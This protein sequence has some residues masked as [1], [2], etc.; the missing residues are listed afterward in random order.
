ML[1]E[2]I[3]ATLTWNYI[4][5][6]VWQNDCT[7]SNTSIYYILK[8][9]VTKGSANPETNTLVQQIKIYSVY[10]II[11]ASQINI[12]ESPFPQG[13]IDLKTGL[14]LGHNIKYKKKI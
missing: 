3:G 2:F 11:L 9:Y 5:K 10:F 14:L 12:H 7:E 6:R 13:H 1:K 8:F 4:V